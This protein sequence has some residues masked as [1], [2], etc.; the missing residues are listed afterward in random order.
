LKDKTLGVIGL[1]A[2]GKRV[3]EIGLGFG[4]KV[5]YWSR[6]RKKDYERRGIKYAPVD[7]LLKTSDVIGLHLALNEETEG[8]LNK[9]RLTKIKPGAIL[10]SPS[11]LELI[12]LNALIKLLEAGRLYF[13]SDG[14]DEIDEKIRSRFRSLKNCIMYPPVA[15]RTHEAL[16]T[17]DEIY[18]DNIVSF[19]KGKV[20]NKAN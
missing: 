15:F 10:I 6:K 1:G 5:V 17:K 11:P 7:K 9:K 20:K 19:S 3:A 12:D 4:M 18:I 2:I 13:I 8:F 14:F 16:K